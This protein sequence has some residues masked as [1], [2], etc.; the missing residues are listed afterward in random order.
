MEHDRAHASHVRAH[1]RGARG[2]R[3]DE[4]HWRAL[5]V[6]GQ[7]DDVAREA[8]VGHVAT[9]AG[10]H[11]LVAER[12]CRHGALE[13]CAQLPVADDDKARAGAITQQRRGLQEAIDALDRHEARD[14]RHHVLVFA[15]PPFGA[16]DSAAR[17]AVGVVGERREIQPEP[18]DLEL[19]RGRDAETDEVIADL[20][21]DGDQ[22]IG[23]AREEPLDP[24]V[25]PRGARREVA[26]ER[27]AVERVDHDRAPAAGSE[28]TR[29]GRACLP[30]QR[31][32]A[33]VPADRAA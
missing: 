24:R 5:V 19:V 15:H 20:V 27:V 7:C 10:P 31:A 13:L 22:H 33:P 25:Q 26:G 28:H 6:G 29:R 8:D 12:A 14:E 16:H 3:L 2:L 4:A 32:C 18:D 21:G 1:D 30:S 17:H 11:Q 23:P 9:K